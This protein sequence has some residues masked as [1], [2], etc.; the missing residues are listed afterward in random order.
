[1][2]KLNPNFFEKNH[3]LYCFFWKVTFSMS[4]VNFGMFGFI[5]T[6]RLKIDSFTNENWNKFVIGVKFPGE[7]KKSCC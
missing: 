2:F 1:M 3:N 5:E 6:K 7:N 4:K